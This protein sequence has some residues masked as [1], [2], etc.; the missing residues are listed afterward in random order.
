[1][2]L[3]LCWSP[4]FSPKGSPRPPLQPGPPLP[5]LTTCSPLLYWVSCL[6]CLLLLPQ[7]PHSVPAPFIVLG[8]HHVERDASPLRFG[9]FLSHKPL[10]PL[11]KSQIEVLVITTLTHT[12]PSRSFLDSPSELRSCGPTSFLSPFGPLGYWSPPS[13]GV[14]IL[15][16]SLESLSSLLPRLL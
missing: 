12:A 10:S 8:L 2:L 7:R 11:G 13:D 16:L 14:P 15:T 1:M 4:P 9:T 3:F 5:A 6:L